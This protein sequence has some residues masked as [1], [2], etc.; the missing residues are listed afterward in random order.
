[1]ESLE[2]ARPVFERDDDEVLLTY[3]ISAQFWHWAASESDRPLMG[4]SL[5][6]RH[7]EW[8]C[9]P[10]GTSTSPYLCTSLIYILA[11]RWRRAA[12]R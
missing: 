10:M 12:A 7:F 11:R 5:G 2:Q 3:D 8:L 6:G 4:C 9:T 1:M